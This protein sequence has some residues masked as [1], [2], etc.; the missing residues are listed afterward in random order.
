[1]QHARSRFYDDMESNNNEVKYKDGCEEVAIDDPKPTSSCKIE[2]DMTSESDE[3]CDREQLRA[4]FI[5]HM[6]QRFLRGLFLSNS[7]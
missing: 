7:I 4:D 1:M 5:D 3:D 2:E 6:E